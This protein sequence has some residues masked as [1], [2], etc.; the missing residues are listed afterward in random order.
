M[1]KRCIAKTVFLIKI[2]CKTKIKNTK[3]VMHHN[4]VNKNF[5]KICLITVI[6]VHISNNS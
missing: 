4:V 3:F 2:L 6:L 5:K 1:Q